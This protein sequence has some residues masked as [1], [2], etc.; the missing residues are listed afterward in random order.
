VHYVD[1]TGE[2][3]FI[4]WLI[5]EYV[6]PSLKFPTN[7]LTLVARCHTLAESTGA[8]LIPSSGQDSVPSDLTIHLANKA[9]KAAA[10]GASMARSVGAFSME[11]TGPTS[12]PIS[13]GTLD[14][15]AALFDE[16]P[17]SLLT[18]SFAPWALSPSTAGQLHVP[19]L[20]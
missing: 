5:D 19:C 20:R 9:L 8:V 17:R 1:L 11:T 14:S 15:M 2:P 16:V 7:R 6:L 10:P 4:K 12:S 3:P 13:G 18:A